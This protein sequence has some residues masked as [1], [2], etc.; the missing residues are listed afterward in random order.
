MKTC[1]QPIPE[2]GMRTWQPRW[3]SLQRTRFSFRVVLRCWLRR[4]LNLSLCFNYSDENSSI[5]VTQCQPETPSP[6]AQTERGTFFLQGGMYKK[7]Y[8]IQ[9]GNNME[10][11]KIIN[12]KT[13]GYV[14]QEAMQKPLKQVNQKN[15]QPVDTGKMNL[16]DD[17]MKN[18]VDTLNSAAK[19]VNKRISFDYHDK[20]RRIIMRVTDFKTGEVIREIPEKEMIQLVEH[21]QDM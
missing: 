10:I 17:E 7:Y 13:Q 15:S 9:G 19:S 21:L 18:M 14:N 3:L 6:F 11:S 12:G 8:V 16:S 5:L 2:Y 4:I 20:T 1:W